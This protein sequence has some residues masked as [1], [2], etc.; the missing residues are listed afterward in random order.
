MDVFEQQNN[1]HYQH[2]PPADVLQEVP[3]D[4]PLVPRLA[5]A[6]LPGGIAVDRHADNGEQHH[7][8]RIGML[9]LQNVP[10]RLIGDVNGATDEHQAVDKDSKLARKTTAPS[11]FPENPHLCSY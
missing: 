1:S 8:L 4:D 6:Q 2:T 10:H 9:R 3:E 7:A 5:A 11:D